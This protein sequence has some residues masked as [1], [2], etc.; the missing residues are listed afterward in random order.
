MK[1]LLS[2]APSI[3]IN[4]CL[5]IINNLIARYYLAVSA[6]CKHLQSHI[7]SSITWQYNNGTDKY[8]H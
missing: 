3:K 2:F 5:L 1:S 6:V 8:L 7:I 4:I